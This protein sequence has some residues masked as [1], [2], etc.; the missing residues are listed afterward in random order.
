MTHLQH[1]L[2]TTV[3]DLLAR[4]PD[5]LRRLGLPKAK[6][7][8]HKILAV[9]D[10]QV[11]HGAVADS[12]NLDELGETVPDLPDGEGLEER[13]VEE[14]VGGGVVCAQTDSQRVYKLLGR[15]LG[16]MVGETREGDEEGRSG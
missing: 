13:K 6:A 8:L 5:L 14:G 16:M 2:D 11:V 7:S 9:L 10:E 3:A 4:R 15:V 12:G 1:G